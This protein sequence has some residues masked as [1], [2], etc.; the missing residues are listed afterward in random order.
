MSPNKVFVEIVTQVV[1]RYED[2]QEVWLDDALYL[3]FPYLFCQLD[4]IHLWH[5]EI[6]HHDVIL[7]V[8]LMNKVQGQ[9]PIEGLIYVRDLLHS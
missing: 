3:E 1:A 9:L 6:S 2:Y 5:L 4:S 8:H 7:K